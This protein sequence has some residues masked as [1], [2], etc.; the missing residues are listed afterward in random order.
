MIGAYRTQGGDGKLFGSSINHMHSIRISIKRAE[1]HRDLNEDRYYGKE[2]LVEVELSPSQFAQFI[3]SMNIGDGVP[4]TL[5]RVAGK[6]MEPCPEVN[7]RETFEKE[8]KEKIAEL[9]VKMDEIVAQVKEVFEKK[10]V[11][12]GDRAKVLH[13]LQ[14]LM[15]EL[16]LNL[17]FVQSQFNEAMDKTV[18]EAKGE[19][20]AFMAQRMNSVAQSVIEESGIRGPSMSTQTTE[21]TPAANDSATTPAPEATPPKAKKTT[22]S[23]KSSTPKRMTLKQAS[24]AAVKSGD[25]AEGEALY[26]VPISRITQNDNPRHE[27]ARLHEYDYFLIG[28]PVEYEAEEG[29]EEGEVRHSLADMALSDDI[30]TVREFVELIECY[31]G[32]IHRLVNPKGSVDFVGTEYECKERLS[33]KSD[34]KGWKVDDVVPGKDQSII[35][36]ASDLLEYDSDGNGLN[37][38]AVLANPIGKS[39]NWNLIDGGRRV[40]AILYN[41]AK[42][43][44]QIADKDEDAPKSVY[45]AT[46]KAEDRPVKKG[47]QQSIAILLNASRKEMSDLQLGK[48]YYDFCQTENPETGKS[49]TMKD[50]AAHMNVPYGTF[51]NRHA[52][53]IPYVADEKDDDGNVTKKGKGLSPSER[54]AYINGD[55]TTTAATRKALREKHYSESGAPVRERA[56]AIPLSKMQQLFDETPE[57]NEDRRRAI[58]ECMGFEGAKG[59]KTASKESEARIEEQDRKDMERNAA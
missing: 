19:F 27:P 18:R 40:T 48:V 44:V 41:H 12:K 11:N 43:R 2:Q 46:V 51:R 15:Q 45:P 47:E 56:K 13:D 9:T 20:E 53:A 59:F 29:E 3:T 33:T 52:L 16:Q 8:F 21:T 7:E 49:W 22:R 25:A 6:G 10:N 32:P 37:L 57:A 36:L 1:K 42:S 38:V 54:K 5:R 35:E 55:M 17:P 28:D 50:A 31:E 24:A 34:R 58:A 23:R 4:C 39:G 30:D 26:L 14:M